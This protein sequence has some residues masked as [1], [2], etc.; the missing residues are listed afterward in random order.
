MKFFNKLITI[1][2][3]NWLHR[4]VNIKIVNIKRVIP[5]NRDF[6][7]WCSYHLL[8]IRDHIHFSKYFFSFYSNMLNSCKSILFLNIYWIIKFFLLYRFES[9]YYMIYFITFINIFESF[10]VIKIIY[11]FF[12]TRFRIESYISGFWFLN[13]SCFCLENLKI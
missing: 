11:W 12:R 10:E 2:L 5:Q 8:I 9:I 13:F 7:N 4:I 1:I 6:S 3:I